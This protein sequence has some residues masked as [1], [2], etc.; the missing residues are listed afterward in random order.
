MS[1]FST[2]PQILD[3]RKKSPTITINTKIANLTDRNGGNIEMIA[4]AK[5]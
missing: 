3:D 4:I 5:D 2:L 1:S